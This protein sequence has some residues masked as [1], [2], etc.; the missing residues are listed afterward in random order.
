MRDSRIPEIST[1]SWRAELP[2][3]ADPVG[4]SRGTPRGLRGY[5]RLRALEPGAW[6]RTVSPARFLD[7]YSGILDSLD[8]AEIFDQLAAFGDRPVLL[9]WESESDRAMSGATGT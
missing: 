7:L 6:L 4:V 5:H 3:W 1:A 8:P 2:D 9:C